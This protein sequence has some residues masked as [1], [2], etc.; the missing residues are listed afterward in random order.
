MLVEDRDAPKQFSQP[1]AETRVLAFRS[2]ELPDSIVRTSFDNFIVACSEAIDSVG[3][4]ALCYNAD[5]LAVLDASD[6]DL[7][8]VCDHD[9][10]SS[11]W[12]RVCL[13]NL[14]CEQDGC[15]R[16]SRY[17]GDL[18]LSMN[19]RGAVLQKQSEFR[20]CHLVPWSEPP[21]LLK[22]HL[23]QTAIDEYF[24][25]CHEAAVIGRE[26]Q[27]HAGRFVWVAHTFKWCLT[28]KTGKSARVQ[29]SLQERHWCRVRERLEAEES[30]V[31]LN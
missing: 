6:N 24:T 12:I 13:L 19:S 31:L 1:W 20:F 16:A 5:H 3:S 22:S 11:C 26:K 9:H 4:V 15:S 18:K 2:G 10:S 21:L 23:R 28:G 17:E 30:L 7:S 27:G 29:P 25:S 14:S 8:S